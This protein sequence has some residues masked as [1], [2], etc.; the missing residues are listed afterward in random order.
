MKGFAPGLA[1]NTEAKCNSE[2]ACSLLWWRVSYLWFMN[3]L[4][5]VGVMVTLMGLELECQCQG[6][7][8]TW[9]HCLGSRPSESAL[10][11]SPFY[12]PVLLDLRLFE[13]GDWY[14][15]LPKQLSIV[16]PKILSSTLPRSHWPSRYVNRRFAFLREVPWGAVWFLF[17]AIIEWL[18]SLKKENFL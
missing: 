9:W 6:Q 1:W 11:I 18:L 3:A 7:P 8:V 5:T 2:M 17:F 16:V 4:V 12:S 10:L 13:T 14:Q 15:L